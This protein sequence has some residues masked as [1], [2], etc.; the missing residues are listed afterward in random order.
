MNYHKYA[1]LFPRMTP[2]EVLAL[3]EDIQAN[4]LLQD[5]VTI[6]GDILDG[7]HRYEICINRGIEPRFKEYEGEN[8]LAYVIGVNMI[9]RH[10]TISQRA[11]ISLPIYDEMSQEAKNKR[12]TNEY[13]ESLQGSDVNK[14]H[15]LTCYVVGKMFGIGSTTVLQT[16]TVRNRMPELI[17]RI[18]GGELTVAQGWK[19]LPK[20]RENSKFSSPNKNIENQRALEI[21]KTFDTSDPLTFPDVYQSLEHFFHKVIPR[22]NDAG[23]NLQTVFCARKIYVQIAKVGTAFGNWGLKHS[24]AEFR[25]AL[26]IEWREKL[27]TATIK[28]KQAA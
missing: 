28:T 14:K 18:M 19:M 17:P 10:L 1:E 4:G 9:R 26:T 21:L 8:P 22:L 2:E 20:I 11:V 3:D 24:E 12:T 25:R 6:N 16:A 15:R 23:Y 27:G 13:R 5:I 7:R